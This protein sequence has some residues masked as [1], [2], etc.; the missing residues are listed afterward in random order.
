M[1]M[2]FVTDKTS[3]KM[4]EVTPYGYRI[5]FVIY[6]D[7]NRKIVPSPSTTTPEPLHQKLMPKNKNLFLSHVDKFSKISAFPNRKLT[8]FLFFCVELQFY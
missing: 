8:L 7:Q 3:V 2:S 5:D 4:D 6:L 1:L